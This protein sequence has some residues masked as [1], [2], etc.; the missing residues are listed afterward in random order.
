[1]T[2]WIGAI[3]ILIVGTTLW[4][5]KRITQLYYTITLFYPKK[6]VD[7]FSNM[8][9]A[10][11]TVALPKH[12]ATSFSYKKQAIAQH[13][14]YRQQQ[15]LKLDDFLVRTNTTALLVY[16]ADAI[17]FEQ[18]YL[19]T[20]ATDRRISWSMAKSYL[21]GLFGIAV[22]EGHIK[23][24]E[25][26]VTDY[27]PAL[28]ES[29]YAGVTIKQVLQMSSGVKFNED[30][31]DFKSDINRFGRSVAFGGTFDDFAASLVNERVAGTHMHYVSID[32][33]V[34]GMVL[35]AATGQTFIEYFD[36]KLWSKLGSE[37]DAYYVA[38]DSAE[39][40]VLGGLNMMTRDYLRLGVAYLN[41]GV[42]NGE[43]VIPAQWIK[44][45]ITP[46]APH[47][48]PGKRDNSD[49]VFGYGFQWWVPERSDGEFFAWGIYGQFIYVNQKDNVV[50]VKN[51]A[52]TK[53]MD[54]DLNDPIETIEMFRAIAKQL[55]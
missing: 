17:V 13:Y 50:I 48:T 35:R 10:F 14:D 22:D 34:L 43:Q 32:T 5:R 18:Y 29:G 46:D 19:G 9:R 15:N 25:Q 38:D 1:M 41:N 30:Y 55:K 49:H 44:D 52:N 26:L 12:D 11:N 24:I 47:L 53:F 36:A 27:V 6:I 4:Q 42:I 33:H 8:Q 54:N 28:T 37:S 20:Q 21:S 31:G 39:P 16:K 2:A 45:S 23:S 7:N 40:M 3:L 51:S